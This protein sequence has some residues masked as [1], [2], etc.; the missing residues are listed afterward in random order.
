MVIV[1]QQSCKVLTAVGG[2]WVSSLNNNNL[3]SISHAKITPNIFPPCLFQAWGRLLKDCV[4][5][6]SVCVQ[7][8]TEAFWL[9]C[10]SVQKIIWRWTTAPFSGDRSIES[11]M[12]QMYTCLCVCVIEREGGKGECC[13]CLNQTKTYDAYTEFLSILK[14]E[15]PS[16]CSKRLSGASKLGSSPFLRF[17]F[18]IHQI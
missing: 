3:S 10:W 8:R 9:L 12:N 6:V 17:K 13:V 2:L 16:K 14:F 11:S 18:L 5:C 7:W 4:V 1:W 15:F